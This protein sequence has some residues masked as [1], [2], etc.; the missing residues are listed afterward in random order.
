MMSFNWQKFD[1]AFIHQKLQDGGLLLSKARLVSWIHI[2]SFVCTFVCL[3]LNFILN[4]HSYLQWL[5]SILSTGLMFY[6]FKKWGSFVLSGNILA[7][8][9]YCTL[10]VNMFTTGFIFSDDFNWLALCPVF[11]ALFANGRSA[12]F[13]FTAY[14][15]TAST[16][17]Y[18]QTSMPQIY[19]MPYEPMHYLLSY[20]FFTAVLTITAFLYKRG[21]DITF[22]VLNAQNNHLKSQKQEL[23]QK[24]IELQRAKELLT[25]SNNELATFAHSAGHDLKEPLRMISAYISLLKKRLKEHLTP[26]TEEFMGYVTRGSVQMSM[27]LDDL[28]EFS[29]IGMG[30]DK[31][32]M[33]DLDDV[34]YYV[35][36]NLKLVI[37]ETNAT[38]IQPQELPH[39]YGRYSE[40]VQLIQN[41][42]SNS[43]KFRQKD[44]DPEIEINVHEMDA[45]FQISIRDNGIGIPKEFQHKVFM[46]FEKGHARSQYEGSG[47]GMA[48]CHK[49]VENVGGEIW[50]ESTENVGSRFFFTMP[51]EEIGEVLESFKIEENYVP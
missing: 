37:E 49:I 34:L 47:L 40:M 30:K 1:D 2:T 48:I 11:A 38:I 42:I 36:N 35:K 51:K 8:G 23:H 33:I 18:L 9:F 43:L 14:L 12:F 15:F 28:L 22:S 3:A 50:V 5:L 26:D 13:W 21:E 25:R 16:L 10:A 24:S 46:P 4:E 17:F 41:L 32:A 19:V 45:Y 39:V 7:L 29:K 31:F 20:C 27:L 6:C 44:K